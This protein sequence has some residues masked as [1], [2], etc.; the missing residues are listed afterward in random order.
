MK[1]SLADKEIVSLKI[2]LEESRG[3]AKQYKTIAETMEKTVKEASETN[4]KTKLIL[5]MNISDLESRLNQLNTD[6]QAI[7]SEKTNLEFSLQNQ[8]ENAEQCIDLLEKEKKSLAYELDL[9]RKKL[10]NLER[11]ADEREKHR[12]EYVAK[13]NILE[14]QLASSEVKLNATEKECAERTAHINELE[15]FLKV[16]RNESELEKKSKLDLQQSH[17]AT[18]RLMNE[19]LEKTQKENESLTVQINLLQQEL[20]RLGQDLI[21]LQKQ[22][23]FKSKNLQSLHTGMDTTSEDTSILNTQQISTGE[24]TSDQ[25]SNNLLEINRY[26]RVQKDQL[27][28]K[29]ENMKLTFEINQQRLKT[30]D[31][32]LDFYRKQSQSYESELQH[33]KNLMENYKQTGITSGESKSSNEN[34]NMILDTNKRLKEEC[35]SLNSENSKLKTDLFRIEDD[36]SNVKANLSESELRNESL[37]G[38]LTC[39]VTELKRWKDRCDALLQ[40]SHHADE[41]ARIKEEVQK[42]Q[43]KAQ[44]LTDMIN[45]LRKNLT[46]A[47]L[48]SEQLNREL[49]AVKSLAATEKSKLQQVRLFFHIYSKFHSFL[50]N[51]GRSLLYF[52]LI[53]KII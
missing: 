44:D 20:S 32:D 33:L 34:I 36:I 43:E 4:E 16:S 3:H 15:Q 25:S 23:S 5:E 26:L 46:D 17:E 27:E 9:L 45:E 7:C 53:L 14:D 50:P 52:K 49:D 18:Q 51:S 38:E 10:E 8:K 35:D 37:K 29:Y 2:Q 21:V 42:A 47:N 28:E 31:T 13:L 40:S 6:Y 48:R 1:L 12:D 24:T 41:W 39:M 22:D 30:L 19:S 11:I